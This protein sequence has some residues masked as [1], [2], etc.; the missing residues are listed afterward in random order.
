MVSV[1]KPAPDFRLPSTKDAIDSNTL[2]KEVS[3]SDYRGK[4]LVL[5]FYPK[6]FTVICP[7]MD[8]A[9]FSSRAQRFAGVKYL[10]ASDTTKAAS[11]AYEVFDDP[12][13]AQRGLF[14]IDPGY[15]EIPL[16]LPLRRTSQSKSSLR[17]LAT[18]V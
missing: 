13:L 12:G 9:E 11:M 16:R 17:C 8:V 18:R 10:L 4:W 15:I 2:G 6:D 3:L 7:T 5:F 1:G 14:I